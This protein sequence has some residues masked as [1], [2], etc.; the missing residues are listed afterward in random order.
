MGTHGTHR[1]VCAD[2]VVASHWSSIAAPSSRI[3]TLRRSILRTA[4]QAHATFTVQKPVS[5]GDIPARRAAPCAVPFVRQRTPVPIE[6]NHENQ[7][8]LV[9]ALITAFAV[10][11]HNGILD[12][13]R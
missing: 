5:V 7:R 9:L 6:S 2:I 12:V 13:R 11:L 4:E 1:D 3:A 8:A 10:P